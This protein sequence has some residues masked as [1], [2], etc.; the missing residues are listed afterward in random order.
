MVTVIFPTY[1]L[2]MGEESS[3]YEDSFAR[4]DPGVTVFFVSR[5][6]DIDRTVNVHVIPK[7]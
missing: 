2:V 7:E 1:C 5:N 3:S 6:D 4:L